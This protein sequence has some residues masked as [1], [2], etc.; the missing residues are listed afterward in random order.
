[1]CAGLAGLVMMLLFDSDLGALLV[2]GIPLALVLFLIKGI[3]KGFDF[4]GDVFAKVGRFLSVIYQ[5]IA[6]VCK[7]IWGLIDYVLYLISRK[8]SR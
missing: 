8:G 5:G 6:S 4:A 7:F 2:L 1:M 3:K